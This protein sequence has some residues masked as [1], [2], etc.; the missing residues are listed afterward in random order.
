M[1]KRYEANLEAP[2][3]N[4]EKV[5][6]DFREGCFRAMRCLKTRLKGHFDK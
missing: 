5:V 6:R 2:S 4:K 3:T 1:T